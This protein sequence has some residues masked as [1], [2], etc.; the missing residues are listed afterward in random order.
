MPGGNQALKGELGLKINQGSWNAG[1]PECVH[2]IQFGG[3]GSWIRPSF[4]T[5]L[6]TLAFHMTSVLHD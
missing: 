4:L 3:F 1:A 5:N 6:E 2:V